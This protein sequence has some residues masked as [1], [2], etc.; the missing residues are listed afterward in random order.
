MYH[1]HGV[2]WYEQFLAERKYN[3]LR[4]ANGTAMV[5]VCLSVCLWRSCSL[6]RRLNFS[7]IFY[8]ILYI[9]HLGR[10]VQISRRSAQGNPS[11]GV[12]K[13]KRGRRNRPIANL[14]VSYFTVLLRVYQST[15]TNRKHAKRI[16]WDNFLWPLANRNPDFKIHRIFK[17]YAALC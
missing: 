12:V 13:Y 1:Y 11:A 15:I 4:S 17:S 14:G 2:H 3:T 7:A 10:T 6:L 9:R 16:Q 5:S 8:T